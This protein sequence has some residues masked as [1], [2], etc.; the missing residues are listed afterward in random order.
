[1]KNQR[2]VVFFIFLGLF[3]ASYY[4]GSLTEISE[5]DAQLF[6][7]EFEELIEDIDGPG[8][9]LHNSM[10]ALSMFIPGFGVGW[11]LFSAF[12]T[13]QAFA[14]IALFSPEIASINPL[15][16]LYVSPFGLMELVAYSIGI[17]RSYL[18][19]F[20]IIKKIS[21]KTDY[22][23]TAIEV[24]IVLGLLLAGGFL[25]AYLIELIQQP[26]F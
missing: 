15:T 6:M 9:F 13:G 22:K 2:I 11:G 24:G 7:E 23:I 16:L 3:T 14:A 26:I 12:Q 18:L 17:S 19:I 25:E 5:E 1:V 20:K 10:I 21:I 4:I 8:I